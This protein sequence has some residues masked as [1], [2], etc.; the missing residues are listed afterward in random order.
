MIS[1][2]PSFKLRSPSIFTV[3][4]LLLAIAVISIFLSNVSKLY[5]NCSGS[6]LGVKVLSF[7]SNV[8][9]VLSLLNS[10]VTFN[11]YILSFPVSL[12]TFIVTTFKPATSDLAFSLISTFA[13]LF[14]GI[15][16]IS[17][18]RSFVVKL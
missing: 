6:K 3:A 11:V 18:V 12:V 1:F 5:S 7:T 17:R 2:I 10:L 13:Y 16:V 15:A 4:Y 14:V 9:N 8:F